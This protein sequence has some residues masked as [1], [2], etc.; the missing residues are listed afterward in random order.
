MK[1]NLDSIPIQ[2]KI[3]LNKVPEAYREVAEGMEA[4]FLNHMIGEMRKSIQ[5]ENPDSP[6]QS[7]YNSV[8]DYER[9]KTMAKDEHGLGLKEVILRDLLPKNLLDKATEI[10]AHKTY[11]KEASNQFANIT[12]KGNS[13]E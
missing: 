12:R 7:Y 8:L 6:A 4:Q 1:T 13:N 10:K 3:N 9:A 2:G 5:K 11:K